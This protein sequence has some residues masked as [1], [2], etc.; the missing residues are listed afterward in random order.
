VKILLTN[1]LGNLVKNTRK[2]QG[3]TQAEL[4]STCDVGVRFIVDLEK[5]KETCQIGK[6]IKVI[7]M[8]GINLNA[9]EPKTPED[10]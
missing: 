6:T 9:I 2:K 3:L 5:G 1:E 7:N 10:E 4:A 8:L